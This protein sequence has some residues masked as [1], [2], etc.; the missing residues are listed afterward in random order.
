MTTPVNLDLDN[1]ASVPDAKIVLM[2]TPG[3]QDKSPLKRGAATDPPNVW[4]SFISDD[5][6]I[7]VSSDYSAPYEELGGNARNTWNKWTSA[8]TQTAGSLGNA[9]GWESLGEQTAGVAAKT[10]L[11]NYTQTILHWNSSERPTFSVNMQFPTWRPGQNNERKAVELSSMPLPGITG[12]GSATV[13]MSRPAGYHGIETGVTG[14]G[15]FRAGNYN[16]VSVLGTW[17]L[18]I[19]DWFHARNLILTNTSLTES[20][21]R[22]SDGPLYITVQCELTPYKMVS[23]S[24]YMGWWKNI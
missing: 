21:I 14:L 2:L 10:S 4:E 22:T 23:W 3:V 18:A 11:R 9:I 1:L 13:S 6:A 24:E 20:K 16:K 7:A 17:S 19:G 8:A 15:A 5:L 12:F